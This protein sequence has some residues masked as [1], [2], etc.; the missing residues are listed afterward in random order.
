MA[1][2]LCKLGMVKRVTKDQDL[3]EQAIEAVFAIPLKSSL[4]DAR[5]WQGWRF[6]RNGKLTRPTV[7]KAFHHL[8]LRPA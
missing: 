8:A 6:Q 1:T 4:K 7:L 3:L 2:R 5:D